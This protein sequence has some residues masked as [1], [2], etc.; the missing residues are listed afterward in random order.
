MMRARQF[1]IS[2]VFLGASFTASAAPAAL[3]EVHRQPI[4]L[5]A[6]GMFLAFVVATLAITYWAANKTKSMAD[7]YTAGGAI[8]G[9]Q[10]GLALAGD[11][12]SAAALLGVT[13]MIF[14]HGYDGMIYAISFF[15]ASCCS[16]LPSASGIWAASPL[17][18]SRPSGSIRT[19][20]AR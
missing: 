18:I 20:F 16:C 2:P 17:P 19:G 8:T 12:M 11:Y 3:Q 10:N 1:V 6:I 13:S 15:V 5:T 14:F 9:V 4:N 7:F